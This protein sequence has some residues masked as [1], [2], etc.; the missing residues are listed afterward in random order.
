MTI[1]FI[2]LGSN[3]DDP[4]AQVEEAL[5]ELSTVPNTRLLRSSS[6]YRTQ[7]IGY[8]AQPCF[9]NAVAE[10]ETAL[11]AQALLGELQRIEER[12]GRRR[13]I[14][15][16]P[17][18][19]DLDLLLF[20]ELLLEQPGLTIPHPRMHERAFVLAPLHEISPGLAIPGKGRVA[21]L[22]AGCSNQGI[23]RIG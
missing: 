22:L 18:T 8:A 17:R 13:I 16:G 21:D 9:V 19:L 3:L 12:H 23:E 7:P 5:G 11:S 14:P 6:L 4:S 10:V 1:A 15:G 20:D 2:G